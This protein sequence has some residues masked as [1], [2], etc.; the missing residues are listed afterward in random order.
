MPPLALR[1]LLLRPGVRPP[2]LLVLRS[3]KAG[4]HV[5]QR[6]VKVQRERVNL[7]RG[8]V[9]PFRDR[10]PVQ[11]MRVSR[12]RRPGTSQEVVGVSVDGVRVFGPRLLS[13]TLS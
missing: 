8:P 12:D 4:D 1:R 6:L 13:I 5:R 10:K 11:H 2:L 9:V 7:V 3:R